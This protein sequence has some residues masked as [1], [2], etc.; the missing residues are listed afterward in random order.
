MRGFVR[1]VKGTGPSKYK[2]S[3]E[4]QS[5]GSK[6]VKQLSMIAGLP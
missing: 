5:H 3:N 6:D 4:S 2:I 1:G